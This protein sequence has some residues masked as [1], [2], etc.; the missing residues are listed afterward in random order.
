MPFRWWPRRT[1]PPTPSPTPPEPAVAAPPHPFR[2]PHHGHRL[3]L[4]PD[5]R[6]GP[7]RLSIWAVPSALLALPGVP[8]EERAFT[9]PLTDGR[10]VPVVAYRLPAAGRVCLE[11][12]WLQAGRCWLLDLL[13]PADEA[14]RA[15]ELLRPLWSSLRVEA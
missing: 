3:L 12:R 1:A 11:G 5:W 14:A 7:V 9:V 10:A 6:A 8:R 13:L 15:G 4:P 2:S